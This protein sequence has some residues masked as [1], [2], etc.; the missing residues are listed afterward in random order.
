MTDMAELL[1]EKT[2]L[3]VIDGLLA[4][5]IFAVFEMERRA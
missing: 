3:P 4:Q 1:E 2:G 5:G